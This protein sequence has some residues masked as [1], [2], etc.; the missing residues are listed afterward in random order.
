MACTEFVAIP[1]DQ[2]HDETL[3]AAENE[4]RDELRRTDT[5]ATGL[6]GLFGAAL[7]GVLALIASHPGTLATVLL[8]LAALPIAAAIV[9]LLAVLRP[10][11]LGATG[12]GFYRWAQFRT[13]P[14]ELLADLTGPDVLVAR[15]EML[16]ALSAAVVAKY[17]RIRI[18]V[19]L[20]LA[21]LALLALAVLT[22]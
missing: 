16:A 5:K 22:A 15:A 17:R 8:H 20:L 1:I 11:F 7:A 2:H 3:K 19:H 12:H 9:L 18:A 13:N 21:G 4:V 10:M 14:A 6:L